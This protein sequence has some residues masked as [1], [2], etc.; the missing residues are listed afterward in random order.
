MTA[1]VEAAPTF[2]PGRSHP[3]GVHDLGRE[4]CRL[5][6]GTTVGVNV[7]V[8]VRVAVVVIV[9]VTVGVAGL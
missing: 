9:C 7:G 2:T 4:S 8:T 3:F 6:V 5:T 1:I